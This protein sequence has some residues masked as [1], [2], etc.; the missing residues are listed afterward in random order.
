MYQKSSPIVVL[1]LCLSIA[2]AARLQAPAHK[3]Q[4]H[5]QELKA[6]SQDLASAHSQSSNLCFSNYLPILDTINTA[7]EIDFEAC[8]TTYE[9]GSAAIDVKYS[10]DFQD[11]VN[12][13]EN[14]CRELQKCQY[15]SY[16][17]MPL[18]DVLSGLDCATTVAADDAKVFYNISS[19]ATELGAKIQ[20]DY[21]IIDGK[22]DLCVNEAER[23][24]VERTTNTYEQ[25]NACLRGD[26]AVGPP[27]LAPTLAPT[28]TWPPKY[29]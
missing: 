14:S 13:A 5:I 16:S 21:Q 4:A 2:L 20:G 28:T 18:E 24:Y 12:S 17:K 15:W 3:T 19:T 7:Y 23:R 26:I 29:I 10:S 11:I 9:S 27:T 6:E 25:L 1:A 8:I 22:K